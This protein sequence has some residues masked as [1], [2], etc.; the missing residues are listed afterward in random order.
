M[1]KLLRL[2]ISLTPYQKLAL[3]IKHQFF[4]LNKLN[5]ST[6]SIVVID[7]SQTK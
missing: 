4:R 6:H 7:T 1:E 3:H 5:P 2:K